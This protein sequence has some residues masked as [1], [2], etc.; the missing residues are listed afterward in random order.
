MYFTWHIVQLPHHTILFWAAFIVAH[1]H[2]FYRLYINK[3]RDRLSRQRDA[4][5]IRCRQHEQTVSKF[6]RALRAKNIA[7]QRLQCQVK[8]ANT[9]CPQRAVQI[10]LDTV[11]K[12]LSA[13]E[14]TLLTSLLSNQDKKKKS[15][16]DSLK[17]LA[18]S[19]SF[20]STSCYKYLT[21]CLKFPSKQTVSRWL[22]HVHFEEGFDPDLLELL[23]E[24]V[25]SLSKSDTIVTLLA[26]EMSLKALSDYD[27]KRDKVIG[28]KRSSDGKLF[29]PS[30][31]MVFMVTGVRSKWR[32]AVAYYFTENAMQTKLLLPL[33]RECISKVQTCGLTVVNFTS[34]QGSNFSSLLSALSV[35]SKQPFFMHNDARIF[36]TPDPPHLVKSIRNALLGHTIVTQDGVASWNHL[37]SFFN[38][39]RVQSIRLAPKL[40]DDHLEPPAIYGKMKV[41]LA[42]QIFSHSVSSAIKAHVARGLLPQEVLVTSTFCQKMND[43]FDVLNSSKK[44]A[45]I[46]Y[47]SGLTVNSVG[48]L[49]F[50]S[51]AVQWL[52]SFQILD[53]KNKIVNS[54]FRCVQG[55]ILALTSVRQLMFHLTD[56]FNLDYLL[57]RRLCQDPLENYFSVIRQ[58][59]GFNSNPSCSAFRQSYKITQC[60]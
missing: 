37:Q 10:V 6:K 40:R 43:I 35:S 30:T 28:L 31:A 12:S 50:M 48:T 49:Q 56:K 34:D 16:S 58:R 8:K 54:N 41:K 32:Q 14:V 60:S 2:L 17:Q 25:S 53:K 26:D 22:S 57:T 55:T 15:Y 52:Q 9:T 42:T 24:R 29:F 1:V 5:R 46:P 13:D 4:D 23:R 21:R 47:Q 38:L 51:D 27:I 7:I 3:T 19:I 11:K 33:L 44:N 59:N 20:K 18:I 36:V 45:I 39:D